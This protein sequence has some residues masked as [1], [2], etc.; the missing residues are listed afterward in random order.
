MGNGTALFLKVLPHEGRLHDGHHLVLVPQWSFSFYRPSP[1]ER[2]C[3]SVNERSTDN[4]NNKHGTFP[5]LTLREPFHRNLF[6]SSKTAYEILSGWSSTQVH[7]GR[8]FAS[9]KS[10]IYSSKGNGGLWITE[11]TCEADNFH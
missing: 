2:R 6:R 8:L 1:G 5:W 7:Y 3:G 11:Q 9:L 10:S 4:G